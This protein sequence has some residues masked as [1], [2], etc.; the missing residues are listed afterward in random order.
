MDVTD[1]DSVLVSKA[2]HYEKKELW[3]EIIK[4][5]DGKYVA[6]LSSNAIDRDDEIIGKQALTKIASDKDYLAALTDHKNS[7]DNLIGE[8]TKREVVEVDGRTVLVSE[9]KFY[10]S[11][12]RAVMVMG[13]LDEGARVGVSI[14]AI[15]KAHRE[16]VI[17]GKSY[18]EYT[19]ME[20]VEASFVAI[21]AN[22]EAQAAAVSKGYDAARHYVKTA[23]LEENMSE[24]SIDEIKKSFDAVSKEKESLMASHE[25]LNKKFEEQ[26]SQVKSL[27]EQ[28]EKKNKEFEELSA[29]FDASKSTIGDLEKQLKESSDKIA[30]LS[31][32]TLDKAVHDSLS[33]GNVDS[34]KKSLSEGKLPV[35]QKI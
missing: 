30:S 31:V 23:S 25:E 32:K 12:P 16:T 22:Q 28:L 8:W 9:P 4:N 29:S 27:S 34:F 35:F 19:D 26:S 1:T 2:S 5:R 13:M 11:N 24:Q 6:V 14:G 15:P 7:I 17:N 20:I 18:R 10:K 3:Q 21:P 33:E